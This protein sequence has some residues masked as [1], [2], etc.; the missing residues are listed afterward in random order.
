[1]QPLESIVQLLSPITDVVE[2]FANSLGFTLRRSQHGNRGWELTR[3]HPEGGRQSVLLIYDSDLGLEIGSS[4]SYESSETERIYYHFR[5]M[6]RCAMVAEEVIQSLQAEI[7]Q[8]DSVRFGLWTH[9]RP[10]DSDITPG[11]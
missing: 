8:L 3:P 11:D 2:R 5:P 9:I 4:W 10:L 6:R 7:E 1:M